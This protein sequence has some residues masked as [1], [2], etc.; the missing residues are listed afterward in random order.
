[1]SGDYVRVCPVCGTEHA[2]TVNQCACGTLLIGVDLS[3]RGQPAIVPT[4]SKAASATP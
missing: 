4:E 1:M 2:P 3:L